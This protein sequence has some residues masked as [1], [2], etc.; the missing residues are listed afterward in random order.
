MQIRYQNDIFKA[1]LN[2]LTGQRT[3]SVNALYRLE[4]FFKKGK[5]YP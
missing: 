2:K 1:L 5:G 3:D 4:D